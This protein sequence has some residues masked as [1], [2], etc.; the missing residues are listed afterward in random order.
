MS[1]WL[2]NDAK[3]YEQKMLYCDCCGRMIAK[4]YLETEMSDETRT[5]C[6]ENCHQLY[7]DYVLNVRGSAYRRPDNAQERY[8][9]FM[10]K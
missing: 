7:G 10:V 8:Q 3:W 2:E 9:E 5:F 6:S 1:P 4:H